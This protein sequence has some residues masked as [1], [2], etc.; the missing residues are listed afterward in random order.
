MNR[1]LHV[2]VIVRTE[3]RTKYS[4]AL[5]MFNSAGLGKTSKFITAG[6]NQNDAAF[7]IN[8]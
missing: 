5:E 2:I 8:V 7:K 1:L 4:I 6:C 3:Y